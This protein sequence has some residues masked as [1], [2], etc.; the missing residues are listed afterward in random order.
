M[1]YSRGTDRVCRLALNVR[2]LGGIHRLSLWTT[3]IDVEPLSWSLVKNERSLNTHAWKRRE[4]IPSGR[5]SVTQR[6]LPRLIL[7]RLRTEEFS[8]PTANAQAV[9]KK[10][11]RFSSTWA[12]AFTVQPPR[13]AFVTQVGRRSVS[14]FFARSHRTLVQHLHE[15]NRSGEHTCT[16]VRIT[17]HHTHY[18][19][20]YSEG[21][22]P[23]Y[24][25]P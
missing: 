11:K 8:E 16:H 9:E 14:T 22:V 13:E 3:I 25:T 21:D 7:V 12:S 4:E 5:V 20:T 1:W 2:G 18:F 15:L 6:E 17:Q 19:R 10:K 23:P 24:S